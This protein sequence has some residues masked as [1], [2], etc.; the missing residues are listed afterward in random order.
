V[1][2]CLHPPS[3]ID[4]LYPLSVLQQLLLHHAP[5]DLGRIIPSIEPKGKEEPDDDHTAHVDRRSDIAKK[6]ARAF[7][8]CPTEGVWSILWTPTIRLSSG[9]SYDS[10]EDEDDGADE[11]R[12]VSA[13]GWEVLGWLIGVWEE[14]QRVLLNAGECGYSSLLLRQLPKPM[15]RD[16][17]APMDNCRA[18]MMVIRSA[19]ARSDFLDHPERLRLAGRLLQLV[20]IDSFYLWVAC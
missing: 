12:E 19:Y 11:A 10:E 5:A 20:R 6:A 17:R 8:A 15:M 7:A 4:P 16:S 18:P 2:L 13:K 1:Y 9:R 14:D 3:A